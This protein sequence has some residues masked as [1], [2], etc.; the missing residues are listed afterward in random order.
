MLQ[1]V[2]MLQALIVFFTPTKK[3]K[4]SYSLVCDSTVPAVL[5]VRGVEWTAKG[6]SFSPWGEQSLAARSSGTFWNGW[7]NKRNCYFL[8]IK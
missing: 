1:Q 8:S 2:Q 4:V 7:R 3:L 6:K 5:A